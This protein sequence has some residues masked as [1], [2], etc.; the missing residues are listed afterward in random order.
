[1]NLTSVSLRSAVLNYRHH[2]H[3]GNF[4]DLMKHALALQ[5]VAAMQGRGRA[6][7]VFDSHAGAGRYDL[8]GE[9]ASRSG[10]ANQGVARLMADTSAPEPLQRLRAA[11]RAENRDGPLTSY[12][13]SPVLIARALRPADRYLGCE[14]RPD[15]QTALAAAMRPFANARATQA[16]GYA[17]LDGW[18]AQPA[19]QRLV[20]IDPPFERGDDYAR[21]VAAVE[22]TLSVDAA[23]SVLVWTP[24]KDLE[25]LDAF[26]GGVQALGPRDGLVIEARLQPLD[27][28]LRMNGC[29]MTL[30]GPPSLV[31]AVA[32][33]AEAIAGWVARVCGGPG[34]EARIERLG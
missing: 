29:A 5:L 33:A 9:A 26:V 22:R 31:E 6:L 28:P 2:F 17:A 14:L 10:E 15:D 34:A 16:D 30:V 11:V 7:S 24:L 12:P 1:M 3:A 20:L 19:A 27:N 25:T 8:R 21:A 23:A 13:G 4:A 18:L 32:G